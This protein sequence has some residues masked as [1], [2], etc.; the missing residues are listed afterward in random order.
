[1]GSVNRNH[2]ETAPRLSIVDGQGKLVARLGGT[3]P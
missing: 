3:G 2:P 1:M